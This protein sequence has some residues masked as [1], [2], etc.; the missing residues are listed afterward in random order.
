[1][2]EPDFVAKLR[3]KA[4]NRIADFKATPWAQGHNPLC[5]TN[6]EAIALCEAA[7]ERDALRADKRRL[8]W[9]DQAW[10]IVKKF[11]RFE[12]MSDRTAAHPDYAGPMSPLT[13]RE[14]ID[15]QLAALGAEGGSE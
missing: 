2:I 11:P 12:W 6:E 8:D 4:E 14:A 7:E 15:A 9:L 13:L 10:V 3:K 1:M 5:I